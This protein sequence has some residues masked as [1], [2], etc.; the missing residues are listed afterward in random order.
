MVDLSKE[1]PAS[2]RRTVYRKETVI[3]QDDTAFIPTGS[4]FQMRFQSNPEY[5][6][7]LDSVNVTFAKTQRVDN[8]FFAAWN[9]KTRSIQEPGRHKLNLYDMAGQLCIYRKGIG[10]M[11]YRLA[12]LSNPLHFEKGVYGLQ[13]KT[14]YG[15]LTQ[16]VTCL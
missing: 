11:N 13:V 16:L 9:E 6:S 7:T 3:H 12:S 15:N 8:T 10:S 2:E 4:G 5:F 1:F 14:L